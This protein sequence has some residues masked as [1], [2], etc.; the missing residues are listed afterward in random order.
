MKKPY[1][2]IQNEKKIL[3]FCIEK[4]TVMLP[5]YD[6]CGNHIQKYTKL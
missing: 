6:A 3:D 5:T 2:R 1:G 4:I